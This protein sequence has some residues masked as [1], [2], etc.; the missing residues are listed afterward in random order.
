M[1]S[2]IL[3]FKNVTY[4]Y[5]KRKT[6][7][8]SDLS[9][10]LK[11]GQ[12]LSIIGPSGSGKTT[13]LKLI[14]G[15]LT[16]SSGK[17]ESLAKKIISINSFESKDEDETLFNTL[18]NE[19]QYLEDHT[20][21]ENIIRGAFLSLEITNELHS[22]LKSL[23]AGQRQRAVIAKCLIHNPDII[24]FDEP[25]GHL[26]E[27]L[28][29]NLSKELLSIFKDKEISV[30]WV[31]HDIKEALSFSDNILLLNFG[32]TFSYGRP[33]DVY[34]RPSNLF[35]AKF[36]GIRNVFVSTVKEDNTYPL[37]GKD[38][39]FNHN[40]DLKE[41]RNILLIIPYNAIKVCEK[42]S[43]KVKVL[44][45]FYQ[46]D[47]F[48]KQVQLKDQKIWIKDYNTI[49]QQKETLYIEFDTNSFVIRNE[50]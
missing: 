10:E 30:I 19:L 2:S 34:N 38:F 46:G 23:S 45:S 11:Q 37:F 29:F 25:F 43:F 42:S 1:N 6:G 5:D 13:T 17:I 14:D 9:F 15:L 41:H 47:Y 16:P 32:K 27:F 21:A 12:I 26:D 36:L 31:T 3:S 22:T 20:Q 35:S 4:I 40:T 28:R 8:V 39:D 49:S 18:M 48:L 44:E 7:G 24:L 50:V 33:I